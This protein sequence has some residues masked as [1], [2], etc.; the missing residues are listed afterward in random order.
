MKH[1]IICLF[2]VILVLLPRKGFGDWPNL[3]QEE[4]LELQRTAEQGDAV[5]Q[6]KLG[7]AYQ[8]GLGVLQQNLHEAE[9]LYQLAADQGDI[10]A[11]YFLAEMYNDGSLGYKN[12]AKA[13]RLL[14]FAARKG[15]T[16]AQ[17]AL[18][19]MYEEGKG[20]RQNFCEA[21]KLY[22]LAA[23]KG[24][25]WAQHIVG[26]KYEQGRCVKRNKTIAKE[27]YGKACDNGY[28]KGCD[29]YRRLNEAGY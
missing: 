4:V 18:G 24:N 25:K 13:A 14:R 16:G 21:M 10:Q 27:W 6:Q 12:Y 5:A 29:N 23:N 1:C 2:I 19:D 20:V 11:Q 17:I 26:E 9:S 8:F 7:F 3:T 22:L 28:Q 15:D